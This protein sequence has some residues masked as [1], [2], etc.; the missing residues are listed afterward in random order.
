MSFET[1][2]KQESFVATKELLLNIFS[3]F[4][5]IFNKWR[6]WLTALLLGTIISL[7]M[8]LTQERVVN[9]RS[10][11]IFNLE[12]GGTSTSGQL[13]GLAS[14]FGIGVPSG[15]SSGELFTSQNFPTIL[16]SRAVLER[17]LMKNVEVNGD[18]LLMMQYVMDSSDIKTN[19]WAGDLFHDPFTEA[20]N[21]KF[22]KKDPKDFTVL[23]NR[24]MNSVYDKVMEVT[25]IG[26]VK[27][28][29][30]IMVLTSVLTNE[31]LVKKWLETVLKTTEEFYIEMKTKKTRDMLETQYEQLAKIQGQL[32]SADSRL[33]Q[34]TFENPYVADPS[35]RMK[36]TQ[37]NRKSTFLSSQYLAQLSTIEGLNRVLLEQTPI[38][39]VMEETRLPLEREYSQTGLGLKV[40]S[41]ALFFLAIFGIV[42]ADTYKKVMNS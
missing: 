21:Y 3:F 26:S 8:D 41:L 13:G 24:I 14:A 20:I 22:K 4:T 36:E 12:L 38:F 17:A 34:V 31:L 40:I 7:I 16:R 10:T 27:T 42:I 1:E 32:N 18:T 5:L 2:Q 37:I 28:T 25:E 39:T 35:G 30:S 19:E 11:I 15:G 29:N 33:A 9:F 23:E 6:I